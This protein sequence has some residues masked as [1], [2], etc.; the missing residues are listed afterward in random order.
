MQR[1][2]NEI[3]QG[4]DDEAFIALCVCFTILEKKLHKI[5][6][7]GTSVAT[8]RDETGTCRTNAVCASIPPSPG[9]APTDATTSGGDDSAVQSSNGDGSVQARPAMI[10]RD[11]IETPAV[12]AA[13]PEQMIDV[14]KLL[15][16]PQGFNIRNLAVSGPI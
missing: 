1:V 8:G 2:C 14:L 11:L 16:L 9:P 13:L 5:Y 10:L 6:R 7:E 3:V 12:K 4:Q 15:L